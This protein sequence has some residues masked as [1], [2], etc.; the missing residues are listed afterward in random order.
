MSY[1]WSL[2]R[3]CSSKVGVFD[4]ESILSSTEPPG[5]L[6][7]ELSLVFREI[8]RAEMCFGCVFMMYTWTRLCVF[9]SLRWKMVRCV[10]ER[11]SGEELEEEE[12]SLALKEEDYESTV[13]IGRNQS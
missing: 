6:C 2:D 3:C 13:V 12:K 9:A 1:R 8:L 5:E 4:E 7:C 11:R 10:D